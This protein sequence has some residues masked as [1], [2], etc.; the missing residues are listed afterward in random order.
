MYSLMGAGA[1]GNSRMN[2]LVSSHMWKTFVLPRIMYGQAISKLRH[3]DTIQL[4]TLQRS[5]MRRPQCIPNNTAN[6]AV[7]C[8]LGVRPV[9]KEIDFRKLSLLISILY[10]ENSIESVIAKRQMAVKDSDSHSW[11]IHCNQ[12]LH[13]YNLPNIYLEQHTKRRHKHKIDTYVHQ[14]WIEEG[15]CKP[16]LAYRN[17]HVSNG[18]KIRNRYNQEPHLT[19]DTN[20][21]VTNSQKTPQ[22]RAKRSALSQQVTTKHI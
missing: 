20:G 16:S 14:S 11:F 19:Q 15:S 6:V 9:V 8:L 2:P 3:S 10:S 1:Y 4:E 7:Y 13:K 12:L 5:V 21:K 17:L 18:A 22:T